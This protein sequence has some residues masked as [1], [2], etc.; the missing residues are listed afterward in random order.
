MRT[1]WDAC[2]HDGAD[3]LADCSAAFELHGIRATLLHKAPCVRYRIIDGSLIGHEGHVR[4]HER[5]LRATRHGSRMVDHVLHGHR[6]RIFVA[7]NNVSE[8]IADEQRVHPCLIHELC[9]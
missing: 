2:I 1:D 4:D 6:K 9:R 3:L 8:R 5:I 7:Q